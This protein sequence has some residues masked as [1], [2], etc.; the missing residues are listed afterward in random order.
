MP[1][2]MIDLEV[3]FT[4]TELMFLWHP[5]KLERKLKTLFS[6]QPF[7]VYEVRAVGGQAMFC[8]HQVLLSQHHNKHELGTHFVSVAR[9]RN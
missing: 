6:P 8:R 2:T 9:D 1:G 7:E 4:L 3:T 5:N